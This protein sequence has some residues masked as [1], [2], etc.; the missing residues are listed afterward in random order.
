M[1]I[2]CRLWVIRCVQSRIQLNFHV[3]AI[4]SGPSSQ[5]TFLTG[6]RRKHNKHILIIAQDHVINSYQNY[7]LANV[8]FKYEPY[9]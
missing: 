8:Q 3:C 4:L 2:G 1:H 9:W 5:F 7:L 6:N